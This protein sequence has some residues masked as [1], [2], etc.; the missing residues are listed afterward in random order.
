MDNE[1]TP[2]G[3][4]V[5]SARHAAFLSTSARRLMHNPERILGPFVKPG[6]KTM[7]IGCGPGFFTIPMAKLVGDNGRVIAVDLQQE[8][9][10]KMAAAAQRAGVLSRISQHLCSCDAIGVTDTVDFA[11]AFYMVHEVP[12]VEKLL[13]EVADL[14]RPGGHLLLVE[15]KFHVSGARFLRTLEI[16]CSV[17]F[18]PVSHPR[19]FGSRSVLL[20][21][22]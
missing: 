7:D 21:R 1:S 16:A 9:L 19:V 14:V 20:E 6:M 10:D 11:L 5:C 17:G 12:D 22:T 18:A 3:G 13:R 2:G 4:S 8:M 15:P